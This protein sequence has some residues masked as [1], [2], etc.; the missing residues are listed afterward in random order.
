M[1]LYPGGLIIGRIFASEIWGAYF[2]E[3]LFFGGSLVSIR[4]R[5]LGTGWHR[6]VLPPFLFCSFSVLFSE[7]SWV[8]AIYANHL[9]GN[10]T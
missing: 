9:V 2:W 7:L 6:G 3:G 4:V 8:L 1:G 5:V 10:F